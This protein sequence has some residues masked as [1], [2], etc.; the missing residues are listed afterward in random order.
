MSSSLLTA[1]NNSHVDVSLDILRRMLDE[2]STLLAQ[3]TYVME[4][5]HN[6]IHQRCSTK[7]QTGFLGENSSSAV[8]DK[9][10]L[11]Q[12][13]TFEQY[14][15]M[16]ANIATLHS[17]QSVVVGKLEEALNYRPHLQQEN[18][19]RRQQQEQRQKNNSNNNNERYVRSSANKRNINEAKGQHGIIEPFCSLAMRH[20]IAEHM[21]YTLNYSRNIAPN[22]MRLWRCW[23]VCCGDKHSN[24]EQ[25][26]LEMYMPFLHFLWDVFEGKSGVPKDPRAVFTRLPET[27]SLKL[28][29]QLSEDR[30]HS[31]SRSHI[32]S[33]SSGPIPGAPPIPLDWRGFETL[34]ALLAAPL[35][36]L[37]RYLHVARCLIESRSLA[38]SLHRR[39][40]IDFVDVV[41]SQVEEESSI[42]LEQLARYDVS[43]IVAL[44]VEGPALSSAQHEASQKK[45]PYILP[46]RDGSRVLVHYGRLVKRYCRGRHE[47]LVFLF[48]DWFC[49][50]D[51]HSNGRMRLCASISLDMLQVVEFDDTAESANG[52][53]IVTKA[54]RL[55]FFAATQEEKRQWVEAL[56]NTAEAHKAKKQR[57]AQLQ[58][59]RKE[60][61]KEQQRRCN[62]LARVVQTSA[63]TL[64]V[65]SRLRQQQH[66]DRLLQRRMK[67]LAVAESST[68]ADSSDAKNTSLFTSHDM[69]GKKQQ[70]ETPPPFAN[71]TF[72]V[73]NWAQQSTNTAHRRIRSMDLASHLWSPAP[74]CD[75]QQ[76]EKPT[77]S[78]SSSSPSSSLVLSAAVDE[79]EA[80]GAAAAA[81]AVPD[82]HAG[83]ISGTAETTMEVESLLKPSRISATPF[84]LSERF[85]GSLKA[86]NMG[87]LFSLLG[88]VAEDDKKVAESTLSS[89]TLANA[90]FEGKSDSAGAI[91]ITNSNDHGSINGNSVRGVATLSS[92]ATLADASKT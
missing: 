18:E 91:T 11:T 89:L 84:L 92:L 15:E 82:L 41:W 46:D 88:E 87:Q 63:L 80:A 49:Y 69:S 66:A 21:M 90:M 60:R 42:V 59:Q 2:E 47:R 3:L 22:V 43:H 79:D 26:K 24:A 62:H 50:V 32:S 6:P 78:S 51:E 72:D 4:H 56:R 45:S 37:R 14:W 12:I 61:E 71:V 38:P 25:Q 57:Q 40:Q 27:I 23:R 1:E 10:K 75:Q 83:K 8:Y 73:A 86:G 48:S 28:S 7:E 54:M 58:A 76:E 74:P 34:L 29:S 55:T 5:I 64:S 16:F 44:F 31:C 39:L 52:F 85:S 53:H 17:A 81:A 33:S 70:N 20:Y 65:T 67:S 68:A 77:P 36:S 35:S 9:N 13:L 19:Q 30:R